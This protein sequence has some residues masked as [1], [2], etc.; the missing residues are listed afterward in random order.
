MADVT[1]VRCGQTREGLAAPPFPNDLGSRIATSICQVCWKDWLKQQT[2]L[3][4][5]Y[6]LDLRDPKSRQ[7]LIAQTETFL[8]GAVAKD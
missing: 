1:C 4:N 5:H 2:Q 6:A 8:F 7:M 3:I